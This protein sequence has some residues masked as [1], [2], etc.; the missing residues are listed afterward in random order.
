MDYGLFK[1]IDGEGKY[2][3]KKFALQ[4]RFFGRKG[5]WIQPEMFLM[6]YLFIPFRVFSLQIF[7]QFRNSIDG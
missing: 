1:L 5:K 7:Y 2:L 4:V 6:I 3:I